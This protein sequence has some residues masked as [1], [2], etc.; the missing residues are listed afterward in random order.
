M[1]LKAYSVDDKS[2]MKDR[3]P[4]LGVLHEWLEKIYGGDKQV[5]K[6]IRYLAVLC[7]PDADDFEAKRKKAVRAVKDPLVASLYDDRKF[8]NELISNWFLVIA[9][10]RVESWFSGKMA[11]SDLNASLR[12]ST[13]EGGITAAE[14]RLIVKE[15]PDFQAHVDQLENELFSTEEEKSAINEVL[16]RNKM[17]GYPEI[18]ALD[19]PSLRP[20]SDERWLDR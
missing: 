12:Q 1:K 19:R 8:H 5:D 9:Q 6:I 13:T 20:G 3:Y 15:I 10:P 18:F 11:L 16:A 14:K 7:S 17:A 2:L 4:E